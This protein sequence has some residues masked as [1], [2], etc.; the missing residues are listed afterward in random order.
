MRQA[1]MNGQVGM[2]PGLMRQ[3][4]RVWTGTGMQKDM[5]GR[6]DAEAALFDQG[7]NQP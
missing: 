3:S 4:K 6:R 1:I 5:Y 7:L 2:V